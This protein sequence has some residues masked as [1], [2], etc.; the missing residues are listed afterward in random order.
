MT[1]SL[2]TLYGYGIENIKQK[3]DNLIS[4]GYSRNDVIKITKQLPALFG[5]SIE[6][7]KQKIDFFKQINLDAIILTDTKKLMQST[8]LTF[9]RYMFLKD[10]GIE[11]TSENYRRLFYD[12]KHFKKQYGIDKATLLE[13][14]N[15]QKYMEERKNGI[16]I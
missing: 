4:L 8:D 16:F 10:K 3:M 7:I 1:K 13:R 6:N 15:Y 9:A 2:P 14:Y 12:A 11:I 5:L